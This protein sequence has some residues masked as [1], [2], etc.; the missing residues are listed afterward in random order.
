MGSDARDLDDISAFRA[1][2]AKLLDKHAERPLNPSNLA[3][4]SAA[5]NNLSI[6]AQRYATARDDCIIFQEA[7]FAELE[8][9]ALLLVDD[10][11]R[12]LEGTP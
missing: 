3:D 12:Q 1:A 8:S 7:G 5:H 4:L 2:T 6:R 10:F 11:N 9:V